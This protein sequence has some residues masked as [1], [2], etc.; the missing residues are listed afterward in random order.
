MDAVEQRKGRPYTVAKT[1][2]KDVE[3]IL[4]QLEKEGKFEERKA[5]LKEIKNTDVELAE[6]Q[7]QLMDTSV[8][9]ARIGIG[10]VIC[11]VTKKLLESYF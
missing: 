5:L 6:M 4:R 10:I 3:A 7:L 8:F 2:K 1:A 11:I 9:C